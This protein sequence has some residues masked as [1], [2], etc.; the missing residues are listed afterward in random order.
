MFKFFKEF[1]EFAIKGNIIDLA[2]AVIIGGAFGK[3]ISSLV[4]DVIMPLATLFTGGS[5][6]ND[7]KIVLRQPLIEGENILRTAVVMNIGTFIQNIVD[8]LIIAVSIFLMIKVITKLKEQVVKE[9]KI[10]EKPA[11]DSKE[12]QLLAEIRDLLKK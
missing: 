11:P 12:V 7:L 3:I 1:K 2:V 6:F 10:E 8:F 4:A 5:S 9:E